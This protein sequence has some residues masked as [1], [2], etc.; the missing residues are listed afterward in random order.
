M[1]LLTTSFFI[2]LSILNGCQQ[3]D[4]S[5]DLSVSISTQDNNNKLFELKIYSDK[6][7]YKTSD[8]IKVWST[9]EY[10]GDK[11]E[12]KIWH[13]E[14]YIIYNITDGKDFNIDGLRHTI[15]KSTILKKGELYRYDYI[16]S[17]GYSN[18]DPKA[19][20]WKKFFEEKDLYL[21]EGEYIIKAY[22]DFSLT[23]SGI[24][25]KYNQYSEL[26]IKVVK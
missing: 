10:I 20:Y 12:I 7:V 17:G 1:L 18:D 19:S 23:E 14:P 3:R 2:L 6:Q 11:S 4:A 15:L 22:C 5:V 16:K 8:T 24:D 13:G 25:S 26:K 21:P 9:L